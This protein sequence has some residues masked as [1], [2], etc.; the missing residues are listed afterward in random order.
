[1]SGL[2]SNVLLTKNH[3]STFA[4]NVFF[5]FIYF[6]LRLIWNSP[7]SQTSRAGGVPGQL[8][9]YSEIS[10]HKGEGGTYLPE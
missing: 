1:M 9:P 7:C 2:E 6:D 4:F 5:F 3:R 10:L 8:G